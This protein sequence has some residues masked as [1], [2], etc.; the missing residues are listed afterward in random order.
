MAAGSGAT[1][2]DSAAGDDARPVPVDESPV[3]RRALDPAHLTVLLVEDSLMIAMDA[4]T[5]L[6]ASGFREVR[7]ANSTSAALKEIDAGGIGCA[8]LDINLGNETSFAVAERLLADGIPFI[9]ASG[10]DDEDLPE[11]F[12]HIAVVTKPYVDV[13]LVDALEGR[14]KA[15]AA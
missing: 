4:E 9:F 2:V 3:S 7:L 10:Y 12:R 5:M 11:P 14:F 15:E 6:A 8:V 1:P 13:R